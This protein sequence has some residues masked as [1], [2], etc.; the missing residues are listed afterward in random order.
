MAAVVVVGSFTVGDSAKQWGVVFAPVIGSDGIATAAVF[1]GS[2]AQYFYANIEVTMHRFLGSRHANSHSS[3]AIRAP[4]TGPLLHLVP[5]A[6]NSFP[7]FANPPDGYVN[8]S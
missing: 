1:A 5:L 4:A 2:F 8:V 7:V 6:V 3:D